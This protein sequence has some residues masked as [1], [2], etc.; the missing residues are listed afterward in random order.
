M[1][2]AFAEPVCIANENTN[3]DTVGLANTD[4]ACYSDAIGVT[5]TERNTESDGNTVDLDAVCSVG[6]PG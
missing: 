2:L 1:C 5:D 4:T 6:I 3:T